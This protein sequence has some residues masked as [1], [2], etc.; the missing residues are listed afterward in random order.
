MPKIVSAPGRDI[1]TG[2]DALVKA[3]IANPKH[4]TIGGYSYGGYM[5]NWLITQTTEF[6]AAVTG[7]G[8]V[9]HIA[10]WGNDDTTYDD[11]FFLGGLM[12]DP[13]AKQNYIDEAAIF[14]FDKVK[15]PTHVVAGGSDIRVAVA[16]DYL[17]EHA[18]HTL[19]IPSSLLVFPDEGHSLDRE[20]VARQNQGARRA[21]LAGEILRLPGE[22]I[23]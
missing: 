16:E 22:V 9:E 8:A 4:M 3:G 13:K 20:P 21:Q 10:N 6:K 14:Q 12:W 23:G 18:L 17:L 2:V 19:G 1:L 15:T 11:A 5:T 7:A